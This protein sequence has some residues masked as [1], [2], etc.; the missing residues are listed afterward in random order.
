MDWQASLESSAVMVLGAFLLDLVTGDPRWLPHPVVLMGRLISLG[1]ELLWSGKPRNDFIAGLSVSMTLVGV[2]I[3]TTWVLLA[4]FAIFPPLFFFLLTVS[5]ASM[6]LATRGLVEAVGRVEKQLRMGDL[7]AARKQLSHIVG[8]ETK[9]MNEDNILRASLES[10]AEN[11][12]DGVV[13]PLFYLCLGGV[14]LAM[15]YKAVNTLDS[16]IGYRTE[17]YQYFGR[18]AARLDDLLNYIPARL[19]ALFIVMAAYLMRLDGGHALRM[20]RRDHGKHP[21]PNSGYPEAAFAGALG[22]RLGGPSVYFGHEI[23]KPHIGEEKTEI[24]MN[25]LKEGRWL[26]LITAMLSLIIFLLLLRLSSGHV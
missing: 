8:R 1:D 20:M 14:P 17:R 7:T 18:F 21:S 19:T 2:S 9:S 23:V 11:L 25:L 24:H 12:C 15:G 16:M 3:G 22:I 6:T 4:I 5:L 13:A 26:G 10:L